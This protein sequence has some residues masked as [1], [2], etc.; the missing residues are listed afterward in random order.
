MSTEKI[1]YGDDSEQYLLLH[2]PSETVL[3]KGSCLPTVVIIHG[4]F[5]KAKYAVGCAAIETLAPFV[6]EQGL[7]AVD[8]EYRRVGNGGGWPET[9]W[10][11]WQALASLCNCPEVDMSR[12]VLVGHSAGGQLALWACHG[13]MEALANRKGMPPLGSLEFKPALCVALSPVADLVAGAE[14]GLSDD[15]NAIQ[16]YMGGKQPSEAPDEYQAAS[17]SFLLPLRCPTLIVSGTKDADVPPDTVAGFYNKCVAA[18]STSGDSGAAMVSL[19][20][21]PDTD[22]Y[23]MVNS[24]SSSWTTTWALIKASL[25]DCSARPV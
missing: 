14:R 23:Q 25:P 19:V 18:E 17:P 13:G 1:C 22:H 12:L 24:E 6:V 9:N 16:Q 20:S 4:G 2:K 11:V 15:G 3:E 5:W 10:D 8:I 21:L 7:V